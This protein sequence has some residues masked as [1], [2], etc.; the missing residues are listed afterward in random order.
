M[1]TDPRA[2]YNDRMPEKQ[3]EDY[4][5]ARWHANPLLEAQ[6]QM[7][8]STLSTLAVPYVQSA[9]SVLEVGPGPGT[10]TKLLMTANPKAHYT[11][12]DI[13]REML[14]RARNA[15]A[16]VPNVTYIE[17]DLTAHRPSGQYD[18]FFSSRAIEYMPDKERAV[19]VIE[20]LLARGGYGV[21]VTKMPKGLLYAIRGRKVPEFHTGQISPTRLAALLRKAGLQVESIRI[22]TAT[23][24]GL[25]SP[26]LNRAAHTILSRIPLVPL[27]NLFAESYAIRFRKP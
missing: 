9:T 1:T 8:T 16:Q 5:H 11:L 27:M 13:S 14:S 22:A 10:W 12:L 21:V 7:M 25:G 19:A 2:F 24:P 20:E 17:D 26:Y 4:E 3:G 15:L 23:V 6:F 18:F